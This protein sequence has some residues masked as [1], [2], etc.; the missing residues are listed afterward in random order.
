M[1]DEGKEGVSG[2]YKACLRNF[3]PLVHMEP[4]KSF[5]SH[6]VLHIFSCSWHASSLD[7][8]PRS[9]CTSSF[10]LRSYVMVS[11]P[12]SPHLWV[13]SSRLRSFIHHLFYARD[14]V[15]NWGCKDTL[16][17][18]QTRSVGKRQAVNNDMLNVV[19]VLMEVSA[20][21]WFSGFPLPRA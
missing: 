15:T 17:T 5:L 2:C 9:T 19:K 4:N 11:E 8:P 14:S 12:S 7:S 3:H 1:G 6:K 18:S 13:C 21:E 20:E 16:S 10:R